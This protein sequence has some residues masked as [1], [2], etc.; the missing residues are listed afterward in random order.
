[1][2]YVKQ[3]FAISSEQKEEAINLYK[4]SV[5]E[6]VNKEYIS[7]GNDA[8]V[9]LSAIFGIKWMSKRL[10]SGILMLDAR[11][12]ADANVAFNYANL[13]NCKRDDFIKLAKSLVKN[14]ERVDDNKLREIA[15]QMNCLLTCTTAADIIAKI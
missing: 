3:A 7:L 8:H 14:E 13:L 5:K 6:L 1:M 10:T 2:N 15:M 9:E 11:F 4:E 12:Y